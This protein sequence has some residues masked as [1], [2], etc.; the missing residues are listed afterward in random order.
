MQNKDKELLFNT[1]LHKLCADVHK[2]FK[3][4]P[5]KLLQMIDKDGAVETVTK[6]ITAKKRSSAYI[7]F[8]AENTK[9]LKYSIEAFILRN[10]DFH[11]LF[12]D[13]VLIKAKARLEYDHY[14]VADLDS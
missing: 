6:I 2:K 3:Q 1:A 14:E 7:K 9:Y 13:E 11:D 12:E 8:R 5:T 4:Q 10:K